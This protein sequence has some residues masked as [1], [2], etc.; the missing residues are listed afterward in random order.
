MAEANPGRDV[1]DGELEELR[2]RIAQND[3]SFFEETERD[4][5]LEVVHEPNDG[6]KNLIER[7]TQLQTT[8]PTIFTQEGGN[9]NLGTIM[10]NAIS[11]ALVGNTAR[12]MK[13]MSTKFSL[14]TDEYLNLNVNS[15]E[16]NEDK[17]TVKDMMGKSQNSIINY[18]FRDKAD[19]EAFTH[20]YLE[21]I[22]KRISTKEI[23]PER[24][25]DA[26]ANPPVL[27]RT[28]NDVK[29]DEQ[30]Q[31]RQLKNI[32]EEIG[33]IKLN[34]V[35]KN[36][37]SK[38]IL[39][40]KTNLASHDHLPVNSAEN[41]VQLPMLGTNEVLNAQNLK[42][43]N[44]YMSNCPF[45]SDHSTKPLGSYLEIVRSMIESNKYNQS[46]A[47]RLLLHCLAGKPY[48]SV[49]NQKENNVSFATAWYSLQIK[50]CEK[51]NALRVNEKIHD[52]VTKPP[53]DLY[54]TLADLENLIYQKNKS[55]EDKNE[56]KFL[57]ESDF[58]N[59]F[60]ALIGNFWPYSKQ[61][62]QEKF[63]ETLSLASSQG[64]ERQPIQYILLRLAHETIRA[65]PPTVRKFQQI[66]HR[67]QMHEMA[68][69]A[70]SYQFM[71]ETPNVPEL[72]GISEQGLSIDNFE[73]TYPSMYVM[74]ARGAGNQYRPYSR[75]QGYQGNPRPQNYYSRPQNYGQ[76]AGTRPYGQYTQNTMARPNFPQRLSAPQAQ[77]YQGQRFVS[78]ANPQ[79]QNRQYYNQQPNTGATPKRQE[80]KILPHLKG[81]C[82][83]CTSQAHQMAECPIYSLPIQNTVCQLCHGMHSEECRNATVKAGMN[84]A[85]IQ[86]EN[87]DEANYYPETPNMQEGNLMSPAYFDQ[88]QQ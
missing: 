85:G 26:A 69:E 16:F 47:Y 14:K 3:L 56:R 43:L 8:H 66:S 82:A 61:T 32:I 6:F 9:A 22:Y 21:Y 55:I 84:E 27:A 70:E 54:A 18:P 2:Q 41:T 73:N 7:L 36:Q 79:Y 64:L 83:R 33:K 15:F 71:A 35:R 1:E 75:P 67:H 49:K 44:Q 76:M 58:R 87:I 57:N 10:N 72:N 74:E 31:R 28:E 13:N 38:I 62:L 50:Y 30:K 88:N 45:G 12:G 77:Q 51:D 60:W 39:K 53:I 59:A 86:A 29:E 25:A 19:R 68:A 17:E 4:Q 24:V 78:N 5:M 48:T 11:S 63:R 40:T 37:D 46:L 20:H 65:A 81:K 34:N 42:D 52:L 23:P 80:I